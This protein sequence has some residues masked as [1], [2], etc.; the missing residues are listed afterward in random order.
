[1][2]VPYPKRIIL[3][4]TN[5]CNLRCEMCAHSHLLFDGS[6]FS[7]ELLKKVEPFFPTA[8]EVTLFGYGESLINPYFE[9]I[10]DGISKYQNL[11]TYLTTNGYLLDKVAECIVRNRL[12]YLSI[13][14]DGASPEI[15]NKIRNGSD[16]YKVIENL[17]LINEY[18]KKFNVKSPYLRFTFVAMKSNIREFSELIR[19]AKTLNIQ[20]VKLEYLVAHRE[21]IKEESLF[22]YQDILK[23]ELDKGKE[24]ASKLGIK[25]NLPPM[26]GEDDAGYNL[27]KE[28][29]A[30]WNDIFVGSNGK[31]RSCMISNEILGDLN[32]SDIVS[33][34]NNGKYKL[35][36][37]KVNSNSPPLDC[38]LC[39][40]ASHLNVN[41][42][43]AHFR[44]GVLLPNSTLREVK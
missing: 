12:T 29:Y 37:E 39:W 27:H 22:Y 32:F 10:L 16:Y 28:C 41:R 15:Y 11:I 19:L 35:F 33:I 36:R 30:A 43:D 14:F 1:M 18:K 4:L 13:S 20:E 17:K 40:Q 9:D 2:P 44:M 24:I 25:L 38:Q 42:E 23:E 31:I 26:I 6:I 34:W 21:E 7:M 3:E 5:A 8:K